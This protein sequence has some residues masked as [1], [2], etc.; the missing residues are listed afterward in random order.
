MQKY[1]NAKH[2]ANFLQ[3]CKT[4][5]VFPKFVRCK[6]IKYKTLRERIKYYTRNLNDALNKQCKELNKLL[7]EHDNL[8]LNLV[9]STTWMKAQLILFSVKRLQSNHCKT[10]LARHKKKLDALIIN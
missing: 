4:N 5:D 9:N 2:D 7:T 8:K 1:I 10:V 3:N 6:N